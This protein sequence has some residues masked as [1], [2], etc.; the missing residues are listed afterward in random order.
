MHFAALLALLLS[1]R[2]GPRPRAPALSAL[3]CVLVDA[4]AGFVDADENLEPGE[5]LVRAL[6]ALG[7][8]P[9]GGEPA[10]LLCAGALVEARDGPGARRRRTLWLADNERPDRAPGLGP[11]AVVAAAGRVA[12]ALLLEHLEAAAARGPPDGDGARAAA[13]AASAAAR[14]HRDVRTSSR[15]R[16]RW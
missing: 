6:H 7:A 15:R 16:R 8:E 5:T 13:A 3:P 14:R 12:D 9:G 11:N 1:S 4:P 10:P 2:P